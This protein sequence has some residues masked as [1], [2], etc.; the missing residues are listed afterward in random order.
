MLT[1]LLQFF[2]GMLNWS[3]G[4]IENLPYSILEGISINILETWMLYVG[5]ALVAAY[6][7]VHRF[8]FLWVG[9]TVLVLMLL[10]QINE[11]VQ[12]ENQKKIVVYNVA[13]HT[14]L[15]FIHGTDHVFVADPEL[16]RDA[17]KMLF[18]ICHN[19]WIHGL[20][21]PDTLS[22]D[23]SNFQGELIKKDRQLIQFGSK[24]M[25]LIGDFPTQKPAAPFP[26][27]YLLISDNPKV[28]LTEILQHYEPEQ[29]IFDGTNSPWRVKRWLKEAQELQ[30]RAWSVKQHGAFEASV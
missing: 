17:N 23:T 1:K 21:A 27:S 29:V 18:H 28:S 19:W 8:R 25:A 30:V 13:K 24:T 3:V 10:L 12:H 22:P 4:W 2:V 5:I 26:V 7:F 11:T 16:A 14:A 20:Q 9:G 6:F 15:D